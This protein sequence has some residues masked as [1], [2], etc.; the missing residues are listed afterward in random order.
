MKKG[1]YDSLETENLNLETLFKMSGP[2]F[3]STI[4]HIAMAALLVRNE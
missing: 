2:R 4:C 3:Y 1:P